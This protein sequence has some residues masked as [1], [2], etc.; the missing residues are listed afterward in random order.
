MADEIKEEIIGEEK[1]ENAQTATKNKNGR[2]FFYISIACTALGALFFGLTFTPL[3]VYSLLASIL[4]CLA[5]LSF[6]GTQKKKENFNG[7]FILT[8]VT[9]CLLGVFVAFLIGG[10]IWSMVA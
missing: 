10:V 6:L 4:F 5:S 7:V 1:A 2:I 9:Y 3:G 8:V